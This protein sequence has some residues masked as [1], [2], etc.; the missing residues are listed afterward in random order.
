ML[1][2]PRS[3]RPDETTVGFARKS[4]IVK[5]NADAP[6]AI[7][8][9]TT[10]LALIDKS[11]SDGEL[12]FSIPTDPASSDWPRK[13][14]YDGQV[15]S[16]DQDLDFLAGVSPTDIEIR[17]LVANFFLSAALDRILNWKWELSA[18]LARECLRLSGQ[19]KRRDEALNILSAAQL[20]MGEPERAMA[21]LKKAVDG[22]WNLALQTNLAIIATELD[23]ELAVEQMSF[24]I[25]G[26]PTVDER[27][28]AC[29]RAIRLW[30]ASQSEWTGST[31]EDDFDPL[32][33]NVLAAIHTLINSPG[34]DEETFFDLGLF[35][36][37]VDGDRLKQ[38]GAMASSP[39]RGSPSGVLVAARA[40]GFG[41]YI[42]ELPKAERLLGGGRSWI[43]EN[44]EDFVESVNRDLAS[45]DESSFGRGLAYSYLESG[46]DCTTAQRIAL[47]GLLV[48]D[49]RNV[50][51]GTTDEPNEQFI[52]W[53][54]DGQRHAANWH[55]EESEKKFLVDL[56][57]HA[58]NLLAHFF[59]VALSAEG[60]KVEQLANSVVQR[61]TGFIN[62]L[63]AKQD[64][65]RG[66]SAIVYSWCSETLTKYERL[67]RIAKSK[68]MSDEIA[69]M[70]R[71]V[72]QMRQ[73]ISKYV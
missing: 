43:T 8:D 42:E 3:A 31:D 27:L 39:H 19:E 53:I 32:P 61:T 45:D 25:E 15:V 1:G 44:L 23:P 24:L 9:L 4:K 49:L 64:E 41:E 20:M 59:D 10:A 35:L 5:S 17:E 72:D 50:F 67:S 54:E 56:L 14:S 28:S 55:G 22:Q 40:R 51:E 18:Q 16:L 46:L 58:G 52:K 12:W 70:R 6:F 11:S 68:E 26:A 73:R 13:L 66:A 34:I 71:I 47:R 60:G 30:R 48:C 29:R 21:A 2:I 7:E 63:T 36:A 33:E 69:R 57:D 62:K 38:S 65:I 37:R